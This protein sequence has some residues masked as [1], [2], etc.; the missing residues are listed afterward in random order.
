MTYVLQVWLAVAL[1][2]HSAVSITAEE[3]MVSTE[4]FG[5]IAIYPTVRVAASV[6]SLNNSEISAE[7]T[8]V[9]VEIPVLI[10]DGV[11]AGDVVVKLEDKD[12]ALGLQQS[13][14]LLNRIEANL[15]LA[16]YQLKRAEQLARQKAVSEELFK[17]RDAEYK[18][19]VGERAAQRAMVARTK[20][21]LEKCVV[22]APFK[23][24]VMERIAQ[25]GELATPG[26][27][28]LR[29]LD[30]ERIEVKAKVQAQDAGSLLIAE[31]PLFKS[32]GTAYPVLLRKLTPVLDPIERSREVR[33]LFTSA[34][35]L[36]GTAGTLTW[37]NPKRHV[38]PNLIVRRDDALGVFITDSNTA[39]FHLLPLAHEGRPAETDLSTTSRIII[40]GRFSLQDGDPVAEE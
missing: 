13:K 37:R 11:E 30:V 9:V 20:R 3:R 16:S 15:A 28:L 40:D 32:G 17:Q 22:R 23:A 25:Q 21:E 10:G 39:R 8:A 4:A 12:Y 1:M 2:L 24:V 5:A 33:L 29:L 31:N 18:A 27:P 38:P 6:E 34:R 26:T 14:A 36:P 35:A 19:L 7:V